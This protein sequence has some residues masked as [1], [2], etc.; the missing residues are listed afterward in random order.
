MKHFIH[1]RFHSW[2][3]MAWGEGGLFSFSEI[4]VDISVDD[5]LSDGD[6]GIVSMGDNFSHIEDVPLISKSVD[7]RDDLN[8]EVPLNGLT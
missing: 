3:E 6:Q 1:G 2:N 4:V 8:L 7:F 5:K